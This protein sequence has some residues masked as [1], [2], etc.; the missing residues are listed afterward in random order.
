MR[1][2]GGVLIAFAVACKTSTPDAA[3]E[4]TVVSA[5][6]GSNVVADAASAT[7]APDAAMVTLYERGTFVTVPAANASAIDGCI[8]T[9]VELAAC[10]QLK[11]NERCDLAPWLR[12]SD[13]YCRGAAMGP[14]D[15]RPRAAE[16]CGCT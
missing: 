6:A 14:G 12:A 4:T 5:S 16:L 10:A 15:T 3:T 7:A 1:V 13:V 8:G 11:P 9:A 2:L